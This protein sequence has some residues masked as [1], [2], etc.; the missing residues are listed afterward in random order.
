MNRSAFRAAALRFAEGAIKP[1]R[2][3]MPGFFEQTKEPLHVYRGITQD[4]HDYIAK[5]GHIRSIG[6]YSHESEGTNFADS[7]DTARSY[8]NVGRDDPVKTGR[9]TYVLKVKRSPDMKRERDDYIKTHEKVPHQRILSVERHNP[10]GTVTHGHWQHQVG[11]R[12]RTPRD[13][14]DQS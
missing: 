11:F 9:P 3:L 13:W 10:D 7:S 2:A 12:A 4:E 6:R 8:V 14:E 5:H 1:K